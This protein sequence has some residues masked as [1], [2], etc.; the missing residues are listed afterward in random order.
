M[1][2]YLVVYPKTVDDI[3]FITQYAKEYGKKVVARSGGHQYSGKSSG[4]DDTILVSMDYFN[5][6]KYLGDN[7]VSVQPCCKL[8]DVSKEFVNLQLTVPHGECPLVN[9]GGHTQTGG[10]GHLLRG[11]GLIID[12]VHDFDIVLA[13][14]TLK[15]VTRPALDSNPT[16]E[17]EKLNQ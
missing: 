9:I 1:Y 6:V 14:G 12:Y 7:V 4:G 11:F 10:Y 15:T 2:P 16:T 17:K 13:D 8:D 3:S 5:Q